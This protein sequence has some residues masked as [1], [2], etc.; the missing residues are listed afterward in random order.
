MSLVL[1]KDSHLEVA[2]CYYFSELLKRTQDESAFCQVLWRWLGGYVHLRRYARE[3]RRGGH[4]VEGCTVNVVGVS[5]VEE[6]GRSPS[7]SAFLGAGHMRITF[8]AAT[9]DSGGFF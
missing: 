2:V 6:N 3:S 4:L 1:G 5:E 7:R 8:Y 9:E